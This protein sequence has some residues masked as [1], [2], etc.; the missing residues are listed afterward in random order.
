M[1]TLA[2]VFNS[3]KAKSVLVAGD[4]V[5]DRY[6]FGKAKRISPEAPVPVVLVEREE[7]RAGGAG[8]VVLNLLSMGM[9]VIC[10]GRV[11]DDAAGN[12]LVS[13]L[14]KE[15]ADTSALFVEKQFHTPHKTRVIAS[16]QQIVRIDHEPSKVLS[17]ETEA[18][19]IAAIPELVRSCDLVAI[20]DYAKGFLTPKLLKALIGEAKKCNIPVISD[21]KGSDFT[22]YAGS[23]ILKPNL[24]E[25]FA[26]VPA[27]CSTL[28]DAA[29]HIFKQVHIDTLLITRSEA[30]ISLF[31]P[32]GRQEDFPVQP[33]EVKDVTGAGDTVLA[34]LACALANKLTLAEATQLANIAAQVAVEKVGCWRVTLAEVARRLI[35]QHAHNKIFDEQ[36]VAAL[37]Q[38]LNGNRFFLFG[39]D[40]QKQLDSALLKSVR[41]AAESTKQELVVAIMGS[42]P[43]EELVASLASLNCVDYLLLT[44]KDR[45]VLMQELQPLESV[46]V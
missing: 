32:E 12:E 19:I 35:E 45:D 18:Q 37:R 36:H 25:A 30:G 29:K 26:A 46:F 42:Q 17:E 33:R 34:M 43:D 3:L 4:L 22:R 38:A 13:S 2:H 20:S 23:T 28:L 14:A 41:H 7:E 6:T 27:G 5:L 21:P 1:V 9:R 8:N 40:A 44:H 10:L 31:Y 15:G 16:S 39:L 24:S 11:G